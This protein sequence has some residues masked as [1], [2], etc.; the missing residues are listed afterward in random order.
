[1]VEDAK[2]R[3]RTWKPENIPAIGECHKA[4]H[5]DY[6][7]REQDD[8]RICRMPSAAF[9]GGR[10][11][12]KKRARGRLRHLARSL[13]RPG[14]PAYTHAEITGAGTF[15]TH[16]PRNR[17]L[18]GADH[19]G[20]PCLA[21]GRGS[22]PSLPCLQ[23]VGQALQLE[24]RDGLRSHSPVRGVRRQD[25]GRELLQAVKA[26][27]PK[28]PSSNAGL[29]AGDQVKC[30]PL[31]CVGDDSRLAYRTLLEVLDP[32]CEPTKRKIAAAFPSPPGAQGLCAPPRIRCARSGA[33]TT[34]CETSLSSFDDTG[35][36]YNCHFLLLPEFFAAQPFSARRPDLDSRQAM[37]E[38]AEMPACYTSFFKSLAAKRSLYRVR[39]TQP[40]AREGKAFD[41][42]H[43]VAPT[44]HA[45]VH[46]KLHVT[47]AERGYFDIHPGERID[48]FETP[49]GR[50]GNKAYYDIELAWVSRLLE[51]SGAEPIFVPSG[52]GEKTAYLPGTLHRTSGSGGKPFLPGHLR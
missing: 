51:R 49:P 45:H 22:T 52:T 17:T 36:G 41:V 24:A 42:T 31:D 33:G 20:S 11:F 14:C 34:S 26:G 43:L 47:P 29:K 28:D 15:A 38:V 39:G 30:V 12:W 21:R 35:A 6:P 4:A 25:D 40:L 3:V 1:M 27:K 18:C 2:A 7:R 16:A 19:R 5:P 9:S 8:Q 48:V 23:G 46:D 37:R 50:V 10:S 32:A 13:T 44:D